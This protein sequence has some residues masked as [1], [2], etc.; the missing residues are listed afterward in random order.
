MFDY[1]ASISTLI[2]DANG[3]V[4][5]L[6]IIIGGVWA[7]LKFVRGRVFKPR[8]EPAISAKSFVHNNCVYVLIT[9]TLRNVGLSRIILKQEG[10]GIRILS[11]ESH[12]SSIVGS[13]TWDHQASFSVFEKHKWIEP[14]ETICD[15][16]LVTLQM[17]HWIGLRLELEV[18]AGEVAW[19]AMD[20]IELIEVQDQRAVT[21]AEIANVTPITQR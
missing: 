8:L 14:G 20:I 18:Y 3:F 6:A 11:A 16:R 17:G 1:P 13:L 7:Y 10:T 19:Y 9:S 15:K 12:G 5:T 4:Q 2:K 21:D